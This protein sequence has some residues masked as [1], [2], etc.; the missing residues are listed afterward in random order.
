MLNHSYDKSFPDSHEKPG[1]FLG[2]SES[3]GNALTFYILNENEK[4]ISRSVVH[5]YDSETDP[6]LRIDTHDRS[7]P[8][9]KVLFSLVEENLQQLSGPPTFDP[10][11]CLGKYLDFNQDDQPV[12]ETIEKALETSHTL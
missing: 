12:K 11:E 2:V 10:L 9:E 3:C 1:Y 4:I 6:N 7:E 5:P 8:S